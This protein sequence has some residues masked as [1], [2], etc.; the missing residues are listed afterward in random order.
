LSLGISKFISFFVNRNSEKKQKTPFKKVHKN[1]NPSPTFTETRIVKKDK[2]QQ[3]IDEILDKI[4]ASGYDSLSKE[5][6]D[7][8]FRAG[9]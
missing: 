5:E 8:L 1:Y 2:T 9:K 4:S 6:K 3:Q 7:F